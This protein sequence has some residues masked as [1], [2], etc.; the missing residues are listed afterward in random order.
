MKTKIGIVGYGIVGQ[1]V[2]YGFKDCDI[3]YYDKY[4]PSHP[5][6]DVCQ[7]AEFIFICLP[8]PY[9]NDHID[10]GIIEDAVQEITKHTN[11]T[12]K[13]VVI[14]STVVP[15]TTR[16][17]AKRYP[18]TKFAFNPEFLTEA[19]YL[20]D[21]INADRHV[22]GADDNKTR[23]RLSALYTQHWPK[24]PVYPTDTTTAE[25]VKYA[26]NA[27]L[28]MKVIFA[29]EFSDLCQKLGVEWSEAKR[30]VVADH[31]IGPT[32]LDVHSL[33]GFGGKCFPKDLIAILGL[34]DDLDVDAE[35]LHSVWSKNLKIRKLKD[36]EDIPFV[37]TD[38]KSS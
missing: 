15:G 16:A 33:K 29:N 28:A 1:A 37:K 38:D 4:K 20:E 5:L 8:T 27:F 23:L 35:L 24:T 13:I 18:K 26:A 22:V 17:L 12:D 21:F 6:K 32:H 7:H 14:K 31:R 11:K 3:L 2:E 9:K 34:F 10:L 25:V 30:M 19:N 36:W